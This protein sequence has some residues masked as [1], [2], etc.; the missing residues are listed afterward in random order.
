MEEQKYC[1]VQFKYTCSLEKDEEVR[2]VGSPS[3]LGSWDVNKSEKMLYSKLDTPLWKTKENIKIIQN[4]T[5][6]YKYVIFKNGTLVR[7]ENL[8]YNKNRSI[9]VGNNIR[10]VVD[11]KQDDPNSKIEKSDCIYSR[12]DSTPSPKNFSMNDFYGGEGSQNI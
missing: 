5:V 2:V 12:I 9:E 7:W 8:P 6:E 11:D 4:S 3:E 10:I 1:L